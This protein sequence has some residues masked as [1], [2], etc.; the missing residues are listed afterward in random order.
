MCSQL[1]LNRELFVFRII[2]STLKLKFI[3]LY[4]KVVLSVPSGCLSAILM[5]LLTP[6]LVFLVFVTILI[7]VFLMTWEP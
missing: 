5:N 6:A 7:K 4:S 1:I 2:E 3:G